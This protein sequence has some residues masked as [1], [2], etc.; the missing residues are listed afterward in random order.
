MWSRRTS[1]RKNF[2]A[3]ISQVYFLSP[4]VNR[5]LF[6][7]L[8]QENTC[9]HKHTRVT[10]EGFIYAHIFDPLPWVPLPSA[11]VQRAHLAT[12][13]TGWGLLPVLG[14]FFS[15]GLQLLSLHVL[16]SCRNIEMKQ[17]YI[18]HTET[19][20]SCNFP[21]WKQSFEKC[22]THPRRASCGVPASRLCGRTSC[23]RFHRSRAS[24]RASSCAWRGCCWWRRSASRCRTGT[25][26]RLEREED[27]MSE[28][29][30]G[31]MWS[32]Q[33]K[34]KAGMK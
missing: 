5:C 25:S 20:F 27:G 6:M 3:Q 21:C 24:R 17:R 19:F 4:W 22:A 12:D 11:A 29:D 13:G 34:G 15:V 9:A 16:W 1:T 7:L 2:R 18:F 28:K 14:P 33:K 30:L 10:D 32:K 8:L 26:C 23:C 31:W